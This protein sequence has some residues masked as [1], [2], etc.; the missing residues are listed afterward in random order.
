MSWLSAQTS[1]PIQT[2]IEQ[3]KQILCDSHQPLREV[4]KDIRPD[5]GE[6]AEKNISYLMRDIDYLEKRLMD[7]VQERVKDQLVK[8]DTIETMLHPRNGLQERTWNILAFINEYGPS[9]IQEL[10]KRTYN[11]EAKHFIVY[12]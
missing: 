3:F 12:L 11:E 4:A 7:A 6:L 9:F 5:L 10:T 1:P 2:M 8:F